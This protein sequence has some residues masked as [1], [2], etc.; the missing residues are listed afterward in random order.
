VSVRRGP[1]SAAVPPP[2]CMSRAML[3]I[4]RMIRTVFQKRAGKSGD[5]FRYAGKQLPG[6][7]MLCRDM[8]ERRAVKVRSGW[9]P[10]QKSN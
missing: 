10:L 6:K 2:L 8:K 5:R 3:R 4:C 9:C 1:V 7:L